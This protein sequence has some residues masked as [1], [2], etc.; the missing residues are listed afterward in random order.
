VVEDDEELSKMIMPAEAGPHIDSAIT[1]VYIPQTCM[2]VNWL[3]MKTIVCFRMVE[4]LYLEV[5]GS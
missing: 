4:A 1:I 2:R 3:I 5:P